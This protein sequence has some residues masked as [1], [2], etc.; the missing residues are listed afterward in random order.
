MVRCMPT[1][2]YTVLWAENS[3]TKNQNDQSMIWQRSKKIS[4]REVVPESPVR[5]P[6]WASRDSPKWWLETMCGPFTTFGI[7]WG[8]R[9]QS[10]IFVSHI[11]KAGCFFKHCPEP[12]SAFIPSG[13]QSE[14]VISFRYSGS[15]ITNRYW[16][17]D[18]TNCETQNNSNEHAPSTTP[19]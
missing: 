15:L 13:D 8:R 18:I 6:N 1:W 10:T 14:V 11:R 2:W 3:W 12:A 5:R 9:Q 19:E 7:V 17:D 16:E 4:T